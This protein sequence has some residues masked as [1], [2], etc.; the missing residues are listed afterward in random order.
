MNCV[1]ATPPVVDTREPRPDFRQIP[2]YD[3]FQLVIEFFQFGFQFLQRRDASVT[4][5]FERDTK[6]A[7]HLVAFDREYG[8]GIMLL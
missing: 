1:V 2:I 6:G 3:S 7:R 8:Q 5:P 4:S